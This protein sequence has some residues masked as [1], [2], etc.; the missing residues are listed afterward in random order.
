MLNSLFLIAIIIAMIIGFIIF[1][2]K[3]NA[4][5]KFYPELSRMEYILLF[6]KLTITPR[7]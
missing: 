4:C 2:A 5:R 3:Y 7:K 6:D 1:D